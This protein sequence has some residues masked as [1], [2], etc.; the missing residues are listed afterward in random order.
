[1]K[2]EVTLREKKHRRWLAGLHHAFHM[3]R[4]TLL[5]ITI[6]LCV[7]V[8]CTG[9]PVIL[10]RVGSPLAPNILAGLGIIVLLAFAG[11]CGYRFYDIGR[12]IAGFESCSRTTTGTVA[13][14]VQA[15]PRDL[16]FW[17]EED[18]PLYCPIIQYQTD[19]GKR[20]LKNHYLCSVDPAHF[21]PGQQYTVVY[22]Q[23]KPERAEIHPYP[24]RRKQVVMWVYGIGNILAMGCILGLA[25]LLISGK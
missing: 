13:K 20:I 8:I 23:D 24:L 15:S 3:D 6:C 17:A 19:S 10:S 25:Y 14:V 22:W 1:M 9:L 18:W 11:F 5:I 12:E 2:P 21:K 4:E 16:R 7:M